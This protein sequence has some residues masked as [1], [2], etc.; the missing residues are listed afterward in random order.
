M[1]QQD[2]NQIIV[3]M[4]GFFKS[5]FEDSQSPIMEAFRYIFECIDGR[6]IKDPDSPVK[7]WSIWEAMEASYN[8]CLNDVDFHWVE[9]LYNWNV[10]PRRTIPVWEKASE[11][12]IL[13]A[14]D[15]YL[16]VKA[17]VKLYGYEIPNA[18]P[19]SYVPVPG[20]FA[21]EC[22][23]KAFPKYVRIKFTLELIKQDI[24]FMGLVRMEKDLKEVK[25]YL[26]DL[27]HNY[28]KVFKP[29][30]YCDSVLKTDLAKCMKAALPAVL[31]RYKLPVE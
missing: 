12:R 8:R 11:W 19:G 25:Q 3:P 27:R 4:A 16:W 15:I 24:E 18:L 20:Q 5:T 9:Y 13:P 7:S 22:F 17:L 10:N 6:Y 21:P 14:P 31:E 26:Y 29:E 23:V 1:T 28:Y 30:T 2:Q